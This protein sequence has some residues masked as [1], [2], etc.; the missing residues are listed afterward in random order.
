MV[1]DCYSDVSETYVQNFLLMFET[2]ISV[3][4]KS[5]CE[6]EIYGPPTQWCEARIKL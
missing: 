6:C 1:L 3:R 4:D 5:L 2:F